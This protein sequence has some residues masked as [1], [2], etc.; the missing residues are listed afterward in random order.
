M[1]ENEKFEYFLM[2]D[3]NL[4]S[5]FKHIFFVWDGN[6]RLQAWVPYINHLH[7]DEPFWHIFVDSNVLD[8][9][10]GLVELLP[11]MTKFNKCILDLFFPY[12]KLYLK[13]FVLIL[14]YISAHWYKSGVYFIIINHYGTLKMK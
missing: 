1:F 9:F 4:K 7:D 5:L 6:H 13:N 3:L 12:I 11:A 10:H 2:A 8:T 14:L